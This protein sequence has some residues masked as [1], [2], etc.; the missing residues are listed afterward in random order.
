MPMAKMKN[1]INIPNRMKNTESGKDSVTPMTAMAA[2]ALY[3]HALD[4]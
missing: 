2:P 4:P 3:V 1:A